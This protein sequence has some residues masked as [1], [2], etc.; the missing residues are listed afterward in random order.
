MVSENLNQLTSYSCPA[1]SCC[2]SNSMNVVFGNSRNIV[3]Y[4]QFNFRDVEAAACH[5][6]C[7]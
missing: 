6:G 1:R 2:S 3:I 4:D 5:V 7:D